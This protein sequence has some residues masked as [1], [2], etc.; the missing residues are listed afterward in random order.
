[1]AESDPRSQE[2][3]IEELVRKLH[4]RRRVNFMQE[5]RLGRPVYD[6][7]LARVRAQA[8]STHQTANALVVLHRLRG[9]GSSE[10]VFALMLELVTHDSRRVRDQAATSTVGMMRLAQWDPRYYS[11]TAL[12]RLRD[13]RERGL[14]KPVDEYVS[15]ALELG[16]KAFPNDAGLRGVYKM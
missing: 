15:L 5:E 12:Q 11:A 2:K 10:E 6:A 14:T 3:A 9:Y 4:T 7:L 8:L 1:M 13:A 16:P